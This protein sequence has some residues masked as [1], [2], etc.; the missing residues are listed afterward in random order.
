MRRF[1]SFNR[2]RWWAFGAIIGLIYFLAFFGV[3][4]GVYIPFLGTPLFLGGL[5]LWYV[6]GVVFNWTGFF[7]YHEFG[8]APTGWEGHVIMFLF[9]AL[10]AALLSWPFG[11]KKK[12][13]PP[14]MNT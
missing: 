4:G 10:I 6:P 3:W 7:E 5:M 2:R 12:N 13:R 1:L 9:Y 8:A 11:W 14:P